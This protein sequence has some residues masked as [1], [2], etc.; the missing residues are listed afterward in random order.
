MRL[1]SQVQA[2]TEAP[3]RNTVPYQHRAVVMHV[4]RGQIPLAA[5]EDL[6]GPNMKLAAKWLQT[7]PV[8]GTGSMILW[9]APLEINVSQ[10]KQD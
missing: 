2:V 4:L 3:L 7:L 8:I 5:T 1:R 10:E 6:P 9:F